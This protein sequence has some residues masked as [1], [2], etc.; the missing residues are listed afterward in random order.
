MIKVTYRVVSSTKKG[1]VGCYSDTGHGYLILRNELV[2]AGVLSQIP[3][4]NATTPVTTNDLALV[5]MN[6]HVVDW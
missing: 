3:E 1:A 4:P 2:G 5:W 6:H